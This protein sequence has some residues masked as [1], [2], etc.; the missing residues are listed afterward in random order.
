MKFEKKKS[1]RLLLREER[2]DRRGK[3]Q[4]EEIPSIVGNPIKCLG[5]WINESLTDKESIED[6][7]KK[8][9]AWLKQLM[10]MTGTAWKVQGM[11][12]PAR[13]LT[14]TYVVA[15]YIPVYEIA[16]TTLKGK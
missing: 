12:L 15:P 1:S 8:L 14:K 9:L 10:A 2:V 5:K 13:D 6:T 4:G 16:N 11:D 3:I 7:K